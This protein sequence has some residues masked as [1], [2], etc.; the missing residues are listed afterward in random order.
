MTK[1]EVIKLANDM[2]FMACIWIDDE[3]NEINDLVKFANL[4]ADKARQDLREE[5]IYTWVPPSFVDFA[6]KT[7]RE[8]CAQVCDQLANKENSD[9]Y[10]NAADW[11][12]VRI[13]A[14]GGHEAE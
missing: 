1:D 10:R 9:D 14:R 2:A 3:G 4:V 5:I 13:R 12:S 8:A 6:I 11:C 7:E